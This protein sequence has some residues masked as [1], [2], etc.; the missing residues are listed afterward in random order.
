MAKY[1]FEWTDLQVLDMQLL[2]DNLL[3]NHL[4]ATRHSMLHDMANKLEEQKPVPLP[5]K[6]GAVIRTLGAPA[7]SHSNRFAVLMQ[8]GRNDYGP[9]WL[10]SDG[11]D[12]AYWLS[13][14]EMVNASL[15]FEVLF[16]GVDL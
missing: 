12:D 8:P 14:L 1:E 15:R 7:S 4:P 9:A 2:L 11:P 10:F 6:L 13:V 3:K 16:E 5:T